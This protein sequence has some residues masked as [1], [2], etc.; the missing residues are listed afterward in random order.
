LEL[1]AET[2]DDVIRR[3][4]AHASEF[5]VNVNAIDLSPRYRNRQHRLLVFVL[6]AGLSGLI[7]TSVWLSSERARQARPDVISSSSSTPGVSLV[8]AASTSP[9]G[10]SDNGSAVTPTGAASTSEKAPIGELLERARRRIVPIEGGARELSANRGATHFGQNPGQELVLRFG[11]G[12]MSLDATKR[13]QWHVRLHYEGASEASKIVTDG[14]RVTYTHGDGVTE[15]FDNRGDGIEHSFRLDAPVPGNDCR[16]LKWQ[17]EGMTARCK[18]G[19]QDLEWQTADSGTELCYSNLKAWDATGAELATSMKPSEV[20]FTISIDDRSAVYPVFVDP[21]ITR[22]VG[23]LNSM[24][25]GDGAEDDEFG[26]SVATDGT[27]LIVGAWGDNGY[28]GSA[29]IFIKQAGE[30]HYE[31]KLMVGNQSG[32][33]WF[34]AGVQIQGDRAVISAERADSAAGAVYVFERLAGKWT[35]QQR[36]V[37]SNRI[38]GDAFGSHIALDGDRLLVGAAGDAGYTSYSGYA[39]YACVFEKQDG[40]WVESARLADPIGVAGDTFGYCVALEGDTAFISKPAKTT[41]QVL[42]FTKQDN[43]WALSARLAGAAYGDRFG[44]SIAVDNGVLV[45]GSNWAYSRKGKVQVFRGSGANWSQEAELVASDGAVPDWFGSCVAIEGSRIL[46][47]ALFAYGIGQS[48]IF[49]YTGVGWNQK[50]ILRSIQSGLQGLS[51]YSL[52]LHGDDAYCGAPEAYYLSGDY[53]GMVHWFHKEAGVWPADSIP[54]HSGD[55]DVEQNFGQVIDFAGDLAVIG[56]PLDHTPWGPAAGSAYVFR[57][58]GADWVIEAILEDVGPL[59]VEQFGAALDLDGDRL[60]VGVPEDGMFST[61]PGDLSI[62]RYGA[63]VLFRRSLAGTWT[64]ESQVKATDGA[65]DGFTNDQFGCSL[66]LKGDTLLV[67]APLACAFSNWVAGSPNPTTGAG[68]VFQRNGATWAQQAKLL[69]PDSQRDTRAGTSVA[70]ESGRAYLGAIFASEVYS[71]VKTGEVWSEEATITHAPREGERMFG[72]SLALEDNTL[73]VGSLR[74][75]MSSGGEAW[76]FTRTTVGSPW[77]EAQVLESPDREIDETTGIGKKVT[78]FGE[79]VALANGLLVVSAVRDNPRGH[80]GAG[81]VHLF[82]EIDGTW[83]RVQKLIAPQIMRE[84]YFGSA[85]ATDGSTVMVGA[86]GESVVHPLTGD[87]GEARGSVRVF[88]IGEGTMM[89]QLRDLND[90]IMGL[91]HQGFAFGMAQ[92]GAF[93]GSKSLRVT[94]MGTVNLTG[95]QFSIVGPDAAQFE[96]TGGSWNAPVPNISSLAPGEFLTI[97]VNFKPTSSGVKTASIEIRSSDPEVSARTLPLAGI[98][99]QLPVASGKLFYGIQG[100]RVVIFVADYAHDG[101]GNTM[102]F[103]TESPLSGSAGTYSATKTELIFDPKPSLTGTTPLGARVKDESGMSASIQGYVNMLPADQIQL[104]GPV[105][106]IAPDTMAVSLR[107]A[108]GTDYVIERSEDLQS[109]Q[110]LGNLKAD[111]SGE[112]FFVHPGASGMKWFYRLVE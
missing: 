85:I 26:K 109:W 49:E 23:C 66:S 106:R 31:D 44:H 34:G 92:V 30:W 13:G 91:D 11:S 83:Q 111:A 28:R 20:G 101:D 38:A 72:N 8:S 58:E 89:I 2:L 18:A 1:T 107:G 65:T 108:P 59:G 6:V 110:R 97:G 52:A 112:V 64:V 57:H 43:N 77:Q 61:V 42:V 98:G 37:A 27:R 104:S 94:S 60:A 7:G 46:A 93:G 35:L 96:L 45:V 21:V 47:S 41:G 63:V 74:S 87:V 39:G 88:E 84:A 62:H 73:V 71:F 103:I 51:G 12:G 80:F 67:G 5:R 9:F 10:S 99:N 79:K 36:L 76:V 54:I 55:G 4:I 105:T 69:P 19:S 102:E 33:E 22:P 48:Y 53:A 68:Y 15:W 50:A 100:R 14:A 3:L 40:Q 17:L 90:G 75:Y 82:R 70:L 29:Y 24:P 81:S 25:I 78:G 56:M 95:L 86:S 16:E 32:S